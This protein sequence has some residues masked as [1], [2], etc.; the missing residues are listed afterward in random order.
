MK[1]FSVFILPFLFLFFLFPVFAFAQ[2]PQG[3]ENLCR[4]G[5]DSNPNLFGQIV[6]FL[7]I[8][9]IVVSVVFLIWGGITWITSGG[10]KGRLSR[11]GERLPELLSGFL[12]RCW[13]MVL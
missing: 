4:L 3:Y 11:Q 10:D 1:R 12:F 13:L 5:P 2:C 8:I 7:I 9:A 6:Q